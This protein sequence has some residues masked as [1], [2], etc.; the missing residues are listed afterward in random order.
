MIEVVLCTKPAVGNSV[1]KVMM[2]EQANTNSVE[3][4]AEDSNLVITVEDDN[5]DDQDPTA[6][7]GKRKAVNKDYDSDL[8]KEK[9]LANTDLMFSDD[10]F[11]YDPDDMNKRIC[12]TVHNLNMQIK[13]SVPKPL[14]PDA[15]TSLD[16]MGKTT[17]LANPMH[18]SN[19]NVNRVSKDVGNE[20]SVEG[21]HD[22]SKK[23]FESPFKTP[24]STSRGKRGGSST[25]GKK[26]M[27]GSSSSG[28]K[29]N[30]GVLPK[31]TS[32]SCVLF[33]CLYTFIYCF[34]VLIF[35]LTTV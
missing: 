20:D 25:R 26:T 13:Q 33:L 7:R 21:L 10:E 2:T 24:T 32:I 8:D 31:V 14:L 11:E 23:L 27:A 3:K 18:F 15:W 30:R 9:E 22:I 29:R 12:Q 35:Y 16:N 5:T 19:S 34:N 17:D 6:L 4:Q 1:E 28:A